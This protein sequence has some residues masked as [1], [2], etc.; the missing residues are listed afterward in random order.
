MKGEGAH[1]EGKGDREQT[2][3]AKMRES[4]ELKEGGDLGPPP[5]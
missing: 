2:T 1:R 3:K 5:D 4:C